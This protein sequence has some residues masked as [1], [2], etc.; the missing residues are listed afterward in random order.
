MTTE[1]A[2]TGLETMARKGNIEC[3]AVHY[4][5]GDA[6]CKMHAA[7]KPTTRRAPHVQE[8]KVL[9]APGLVNDHIEDT[10]RWE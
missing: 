7:T 6:G 3:D 10:L 8:R 2:E 9:A 4:C 5:V 1:N